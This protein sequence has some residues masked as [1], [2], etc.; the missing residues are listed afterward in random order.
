MKYIQSIVLFAALGFLTNCSTEQSG[1]RTDVVA[2]IRLQDST[3]QVRD[4]LS[5]AGLNMTVGWRAEDLILRRLTDTQVVYNALQSLHQQ[6][7][8]NLPVE[9]IALQA[10]F[11]S[12][13][14]PDVLALQEV[15]TMWLA[16][17]LVVDYLDT[18]QHF[19]GFYAQVPRYRVFRQE[20]N[21]ITLAVRDSNSGQVL[22]ID[23]WEGNALLVR[24]DLEILD[25]GATL[26]RDAVQF[27]ILS[28]TIPSERGMQWLLLN[29]PGGELWRVVNTHLEIEDLSIINKQQSVELNSLLWDFWQEAQFESQV[30]VADLNSIP[31]RGSHATLTNT[32]T[33]FLDVHAEF[34]DVA[35][36]PSCCISFFTDPL[37]DFDRRLDYILARN[38]YDARDARTTPL[39]VQEAQAVAG[40]TGYAGP[41][42]AGDHGLVSALLRRF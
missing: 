6:M 2:N 41:L 3:G 19:L 29:G 23:F 9:R 34:A 28:D 15:Q 17:T 21:R 13:D 35:D 33:G 32:A 1:N 14:P 4:S 24:E 30:V 38:I 27:V 10:A 16:D 5:V 40:V 11:I 7:V 42:W 8:A 36:A 37:E 12:L 22:D 31:G 26:L 39:F 25:S 20:L 18:L